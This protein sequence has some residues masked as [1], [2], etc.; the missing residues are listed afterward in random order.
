MSHFKSHSFVAVLVGAVVMTAGSAMGQ[1]GTLELFPGT[2]QTVVDGGAGDTD[3]LVNDVIVIDPASPIVVPNTTNVNGNSVLFAGEVIWNSTVNTGGMAQSVSLSVTNA[4]FT[5]PGPDG[6]GGAFPLAL[7]R[8][9]GYAASVGNTTALIGGTINT[10]DGTS[11]TPGP[12]QRLI[13]VRAQDDTVDYG[14]SFGTNLAPIAGWQNSNT[15][16]PPATSP[17][18]ISGFDTASGTYP[19]ATMPTATFMLN[20]EDLYLASREQ[21]TFPT[22]IDGGLVVVPEPT[23]LALL[24]I[25]ALALIRRRRA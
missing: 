7:R 19:V 10:T 24:G 3:G 14:G 17:M 5:N 23:G 16:I 9:P 18:S 12:I 22:S 15:S 8:H 11:H 13:S 21:M 6:L 25:G 20:V 1:L 4:T 2:A